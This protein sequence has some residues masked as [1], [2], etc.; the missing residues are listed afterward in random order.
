MVAGALNLHHVLLDGAIWKLRSGAVARILIRGA[1]EGAQ[2]PAPARRRLPLAPLVWASGAVGVALMGLGTLEYEF[3][4][5]RAAARGDLGRLETASQRLAWLGRDDPSL[6][7][8]IGGLR[9]EA[10]DRDGA[11]RA[12]EQSLALHPTANAWV[13]LGVLHEREGAQAEALAAYQAALALRPQDVAALHYA[14]R[15]ELAAGHAERAR[16]LLGEAARLAPEQPE[17]RRSLA[18]A[19]AAAAPAT[20]PGVRRRPAGSP[21]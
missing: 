11:R 16:E 15:A 9:A 4:F 18:R 12:F 20:S 17:I 6:R 2:A 1:A 8:L 13:D 3:G 7:A 14:G 5:R 10:G 21:P 19:Q